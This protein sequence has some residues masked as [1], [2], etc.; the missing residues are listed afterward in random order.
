M[1]GK[2]YGW[3][4]QKSNWAG[5]DEVALLGRVFS[6]LADLGAIFLLYLIAA[7]LYGRKVALLAAAFA[8]VAVMEF[9]QWHFWTTDNFLI[10]FLLLRRYF[11]VEVA[12]GNPAVEIWK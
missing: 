9:Q 3:L 4:A 2:F 12:F 6:A 11:A 8:S 7:R 10:F 1:P 5:Y